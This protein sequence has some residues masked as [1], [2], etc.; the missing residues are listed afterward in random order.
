MTARAS[1]NKTTDKKLA[2]MVNYGLVINSGAKALYSPD[3]S[4]LTIAGDLGD[5]VIGYGGGVGD[6]IY[7]N[8]DLPVVQIGQSSEDG[9]IKIISMAWFIKSGI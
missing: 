9:I 4:T 5:I 8:A 6:N 3:S 2:C 7:S 1:G